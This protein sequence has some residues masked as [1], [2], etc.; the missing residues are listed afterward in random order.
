MSNTTVLARNAQLVRRPVYVTAFVA[1]LAGA[2][3]GC[4]STGSS[5]SRYN[6]PTTGRQYDDSS[7]AAQ[8]RIAID[9]LQSAGKYDAQWYMQRASQA[10]VPAVWV[11]EARQAV[12]ENE[13]NRAAV[14]AARVRVQAG[15]SEALGYADAD[16]E[17]AATR[18]KASL[19]DARRIQD[20][21][22]ARLT[23][24]DAFALAQES[25]VEEDARHGDAVVRATLKERQAEFERLRSLALAEHQA[26]QAE[27][28]RMLAQRAYVS[29]QGRSEIEQMVQ[30]AQLTETRAVSRVKDLKATS[31]AVAQ[32]SVARVADLDQQVRTTNTTIVARASSLRE[33]ARNMQTQARADATEL[34][35]RAD[36]IESSG[37]QSEYDLAVRTADLENT[38]VVAE[39]DE[40]RQQ[41]EATLTGTEAELTRRRADAEKF[42][43]VAGAHL[44]ERKSKVETL[45]EARLA[46]VFLFRAQAEN[47][48]RQARAE[49]VQAEA[50]AVAR[51]QREQAAHT[52]DVAQKQADEVQAQAEAECARLRAELM[53]QI[54]S[55]MAAG[56]VQLPGMLVSANGGESFDEPLPTQVMVALPPAVIEPERIAIFRSALAEAMKINATADALEQ[57]CLASYDE[58]STSLDAWWSQKQSQ[59]DQFLAEANALE[60]KSIAHAAELTARAESRLRQGEA[61]MI[62]AKTGAEAGRKDAAA[63][64]T[65][66]RATAVAL[67]QKADAAMTQ[68]LAEADACE[69]SGKAQVQSLTAQRD[70][71]KQRG[72]AK[73]RALSAEGESLEKSQASV[74]AQMRQEIKTSEQVLIA[75]MNRLDQNA[76]SFIQCAEASHQE[77]TAVAG[78]FDKQ[79]G[80]LVGRMQADIESDRQ[81][82]L[83]G[84]EH[85]R[86]VV[87]AEELAGQGVVERAIAGAELEKGVY[88]SMDS[89][90]RARIMSGADQRLADVNARLA[91]VDATDESIRAMFEARIVGVEADRDRAYAR[92]Y[93]SEREMLARRD[94]AQA[95]AIA[96]QEISVAALKRLERSKQAFQMSAQD[97]WDARLAIPGALTPEELSATHW[98]MTNSEVFGTTIAGMPGDDE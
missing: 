97:N 40:L 74:V 51:A 83:A 9:P 55:Q 62:H 65:G 30:V 73:A 64:I 57:A 61:C 17:R 91:M 44:D 86:N 18:E 66:L 26:A 7:L 63:Q 71:E 19:A 25:A 43:S 37:A 94:Q 92:R 36:A 27:H 14:Q 72:E 4:S 98:L 89:V 34:L 13:K 5:A 49:F 87:Q 52:V 68:M 29:D 75:E 82:G 3:A 77:A 33:R 15:Q 48:E 67:Q 24:M 84:V 70:A 54:A 50:A 6:W 16:L 56:G 42:L 2:L 32:S 58:E 81:S 28:Q 20:S 47:V 46:D 69:Q 76:N 22:D 53:S 88:D 23:E 95:A 93:L 38:K 80:I 60:Q 8:S 90:R 10:S 1:A 35:A 39:V 96:Y 41:A 85:M 79:T 21:L 12:T 45:R 59:Y 31:V 11:S 78:C